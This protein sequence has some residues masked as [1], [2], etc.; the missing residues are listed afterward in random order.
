MS[1]KFV[2]PKAATRYAIF[3]NRNKPVFKAY[4][5]LGHA[6]LSW[7]H[8]ARG[9]FD[10]KLLE[11]IDGEW[12]VLFDIPKGTSTA[13]W[14]KK[15][16]RRWTS[17]EFNVAVPMSR[18]EYAEWRLKVERERVAESRNLEQLSQGSK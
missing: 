4:N 15:T 14:T 6:K 3:V 11:N 7:R 2:P 1:L 18:D 16:K 5:N 13:P 10:A 8:G 9:R 12:Y 17:Y